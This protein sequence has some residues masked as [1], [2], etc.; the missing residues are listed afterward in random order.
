MPWNFEP[1]HF[2]LYQAAIDNGTI[3][4]LSNWEMWT[5]KGLPKNIIYVPQCRTANEA[6]QI[7]DYLAGY[8]T[9]DQAQGSLGFNEPDI[10]SQASLSVET[11]VELWQKHVLPMKQKYPGLRIGS[12]AVSNGP[13]GL[14][15]LERFVEC[16][17]GV[18]GAGIDHIC[19][20]YY[21]PDVEHFKNYVAEA[22]KI[23]GLPVWVTEFA[24][25]RWDPSNP[26]N[27]EEVCSFMSE[28]LRFLDDTEYV[29]RYAWFGA[30]SDVGEGVG[31]CNGLQND[32]QLSR[33]GQLYCA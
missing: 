3:A 22:H 31:R 24:C 8:E 14:P 18:G 23:F 16:L 28:A 26:C 9:N 30:M 2:E 13:E 17:G 21:S 1:N 27:D 33:T 32:G 11:A 7:A 6:N 5:P 29:E 20:H 10:K 25:T 15:W 4:W 12:P 19:I